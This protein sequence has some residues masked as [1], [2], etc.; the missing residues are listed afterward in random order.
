MGVEIHKNVSNK[1]CDAGPMSA[2]FKHVRQIV[3]PAGELIT[4]SGPI[5]ELY[6]HIRPSLKAY[7]SLRGLS[8]EHSEDVIQ[9]AFLRLVRHAARRE[10]NENL[11]AWV[12]R[13]AHNLSIDFHRSQKRQ[14]H[15]SEMEASLALHGRVD[16]APN[17]EQKIILQ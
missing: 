9:E 4:G 2:E 8:N 14:P 1:L 16:P 11:R 3:G 17:P 15:G 10:V 6:D 5:V 12:F 13:V 7:L